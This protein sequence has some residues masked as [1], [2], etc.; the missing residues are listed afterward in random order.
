MLK[1]LKNLFKPRDP[2]EEYL[3]KSSDLVDLENRMKEL[4]HKGIWI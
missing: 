1:F 4:K 3:A 2:V